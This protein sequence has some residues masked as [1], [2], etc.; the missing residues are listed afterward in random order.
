MSQYTKSV[1][2]KTFVS[3]P[4]VRVFSTP[5]L[6]PYFM[7]SEW[8]EMIGTNDYVLLFDWNPWWSLKKDQ[9]AKLIPSQHRHQFIFMSGTEAAHA[10][11]LD[12]G[13]QSH[14][15]SN[16]IHLNE[17]E[18]DL[19]PDVVPEFDA[20]CVARAAS[21]KRIGLAASVPRAALVVDRW[22]ESS[23]AKPDEA[24]QT[25]PA[26]WINERK[27]SV[28]EVAQVYPRAKVGLALS[29]AEGACF[30]VTEALLCGRPVVSTRA[31]DGFGLGGRE[32]WLNDRNST[33]C[34]PNP[35]A[36][37]AAVAD[38]IS[39]DL[40]PKAVRDDALGEIRRQ[41]RVVADEVLQ[42]I[43]DR[44]GVGLSGRQLMEEDCFES[45]GLLRHRLGAEGRPLSFDELRA[46]L[47]PM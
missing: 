46:A 37:A 2:L 15:I 29:M 9:W 31:Q 13:Y 3:T 27:L 45:K 8:A 22:F 26:A 41:R 34:D 23:F 42:P 12:L 43:F 30:T 21:F 38:L 47:A 39:R 16:N 17:N 18:F 44:H 32:L 1:P 35:A 33:Y 24:W 19:R 36:V 28:R 11:R 6:W 40:D 5:A 4:G 7:I 20:V 10:M 14:L 25:V